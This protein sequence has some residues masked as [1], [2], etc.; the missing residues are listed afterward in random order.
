MVPAGVVHAEQH[1]AETSQPCERFERL[2]RQRR[3]AEDNNPGWQA[4]WRLLQAIDPLDKALMD[5]GA[6]LG[7]ALFT[8]IQQQGAP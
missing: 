4:R 2:G 3:N 6:A 5:T 8:D 1:L 7:H